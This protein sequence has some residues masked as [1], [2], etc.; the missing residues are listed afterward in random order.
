LISAI[1]DF[2]RPSKLHHQFGW[3]SGHLQHTDAIYYGAIRQ[4]QCTRTGWRFNPNPTLNNSRHYL[5]GIDSG[6]E[7]C[8][9]HYS[10][11]WAFRLSRRWPR[12]GPHVQLLRDKEGIRTKRRMGL[13]RGWRYFRSYIT[14]TSQKRVSVARRYQADWDAAK[15]IQIP[16]F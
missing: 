8:R 3:V 10:T 6:R 16:S 4:E 13:G 2:G 11:K 7:T 5:D 14:R 9:G 1:R 15:T 12:K